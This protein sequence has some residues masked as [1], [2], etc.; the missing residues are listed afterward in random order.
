MPAPIP[1]PRRLMFHHHHDSCPD[2]QDMPAWAR[3]FLTEMS[4]IMSA[5]QDHLNAVTTRLET[6]LTAYAVALVPPTP[7]DFVTLDQVTLN[8]EAAVA[9][10]PPVPVA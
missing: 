6:A 10:L 5:D 1:D 8:A 3:H 7:I 4:A 2:C 9:A